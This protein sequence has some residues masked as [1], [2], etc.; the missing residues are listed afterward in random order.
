MLTAVVRQCSQDGEKLSKDQR[1][2]LAALFQ[3]VAAAGSAA[4]WFALAPLVDRARPTPDLVYVSLELNAG[5]FPSGHVLN[6][7]AGFGFAWFLAWTLLPAGW[8]RTAVLWL[9]PV[10]LLA[11]GVSRVF[12]GQHWSSDVV[13][14]YLIGALWAI[15]GAPGERS[16]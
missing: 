7:T 2:F 11:L 6:L 15:R 10:Y 5:S 9:V 3:V 1:R 16:S 4:L 14:G 8:F 12:S 13:G